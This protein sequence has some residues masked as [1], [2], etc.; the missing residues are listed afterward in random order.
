MGSRDHAGPAHRSRWRDGLCCLPLC[1][2]GSTPRTTSVSRL[3]VPAYAH[4]YRRFA[5]ALA[6][7][8]AR[9]GADVD[10]YSFIA[11][12]LH[13][14]HFAGFAGAPRTDPGERNYR[15][16]LRP[17]VMTSNRQSGQGCRSFGLGNQ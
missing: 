13:L 16:G 5:A 11:E 2:R 9:L 1:G 14:L 4:P 12:D 15:T 8:D 10:R 7:D 6:D 3:F 17:R